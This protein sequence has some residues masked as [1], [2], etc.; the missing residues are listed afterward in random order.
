MDTPI[1]WV[2]HRGAAADWPENTLL[3]LDAAVAAGVRWVEVDVQLCADGVPVLLHD[4][5]LQRVAHRPESVFSL[6][7]DAL[8]A[9][10]VGEPARFGNRFTAARAPTVARF[11]DWLARHEAVQAFVELKPES[12]ARFGRH[13]VLEA[14]RRALAPVAQRWAPI[15]F[16]YEMLALAADA[17]CERVGWVVRGFD[18]AV[19]GRARA[20]PARWLFCNHLR[21]PP[22]PLPR[23]PWDWVL[24]E[25]GDAE[26]A[27]ALVERGARWLE[28]MAVVEL[29]HALGDA[30]GN[31]V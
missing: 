3:A 9:I 27:Q 13:A 17:G 29:Q 2:A 31:P 30:P 23:G 20:L 21:L 24:Y 7:S 10:A 15:S 14:C 28:S 1:Q 4:A 11:A 19:A 18:E 25:V 22:G 6:G 16:D 26:T 8:A 5:D 12:I